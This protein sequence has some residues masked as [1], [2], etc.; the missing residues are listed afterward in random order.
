MSLSPEK[1]GSLWNSVYAANFM[2]DL[3]NCSP[4]AQTR[5]RLREMAGNAVHVAD[6]AVEALWDWDNGRKQIEDEDWDC[7]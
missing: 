6:L 3:E 1:R 7:Y 4:H 5:D 2:V